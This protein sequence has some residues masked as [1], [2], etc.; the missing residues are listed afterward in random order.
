MDMPMTI[1]QL[2]ARGAGNTTRPGGLDFAAGDYSDYGMS[3]ASQ[4]FLKP[5]GLTALPGSLKR[6][7]ASDPTHSLPLTILLFLPTLLH[8]QAPAAPPN[9][10]L[11]LDGSGDYVRLPSKGFA[12]FQQATI[13]AWVKWRSFGGSAR[14]FDFGARQREMYV[15]AEAG[16]LTP[17]STAMKFLVADAAGT[18]RREDVYGGF[19]LNEWTHLAV[20]TGPGGVR[21]YLNGVLMATN[22]FAGSLSTLGSENYFLGRQ[23]YTEVVVAP[24]D[25]QLDEVS[26]W[27]VMRTAEE[28]RTIMPMIDGFAFLEEF[29]RQPGAGEVPVIVI[30][31]K[32]L[33]DDDHRQLDTTATRIF[34][35]R[36]ISAD[37]LLRE[38]RA[39][40]P[41]QT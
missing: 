15:R 16:S 7:A 24:F 28:I 33:T 6:H 30:T 37:N 36:A 10:V 12:K 5:P 19:R 3:A 2:E 27:S 18:R 32:D 35:K 29:R 26:V 11:D 40:L 41:I 39:L 17:H 38:I 21:V 9:R 25:G 13:E 8:A 34:Q 22:D 23:N 31:V 4:R 20:V 14:V 1:S